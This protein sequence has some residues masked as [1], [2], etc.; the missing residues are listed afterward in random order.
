MIPVTH[1]HLF[2]PQPGSRFRIWTLDLAP[3]LA[4]MKLSSVFVHPLSVLVGM[5]AAVSNALVT[6]QCPADNDSDLNATSAASSVIV[7]RIR[8]DIPGLI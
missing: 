1:S 2:L 8:F 5:K 6:D 4:G 3:C 7:V